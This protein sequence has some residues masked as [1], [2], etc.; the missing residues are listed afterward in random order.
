MNP[1]RNHPCDNCDI[2]QSGICCG[3]EVGE[4]NLPYQ[5]SYPDEF[6]GNVGV[7]LEKDGK[8]QCHICGRWFIELG[9]H[10]STKHKVSAD[11][12]RA[13]FGLA[14]GRAL[15]P[16]SLSDIRRKNALSSGLGK[17]RT[18]PNMTSEQRS[19]IAYKREARIETA[20][21]RTEFLKT[22]ARKGATARWAIDRPQKSKSK[23]ILKRYPR[24]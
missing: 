2:C 7:L 1:C 20:I 14:C 23:I 8:V 3:A 4:P 21:K 11:E 16:Q 12:Y 5:G 19:L 6:Y 10:T 15:C 9:R 13:Y 18:L 17:G 24:E 22:I